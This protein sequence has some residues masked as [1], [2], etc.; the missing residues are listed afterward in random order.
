MAGASNSLKCFLCT[1]TGIVAEYCERFRCAKQIQ[2]PLLL[3]Y[4]SCV[5]LW[6]HFWSQLCVLRHRDGIHVHGLYD[7]FSNRAGMCSSMRCDIFQGVR[8]MERSPQEPSNWWITFDCFELY[9][10]SFSAI[11]SHLVVSG[12]KVNNTSTM[13]HNIRNSA[14]QQ[15]MIVARFGKI[16]HPIT[17]SQVISNEHI[18]TVRV[19][20][21]YIQSNMYSINKPNLISIWSLTSFSTLQARYN[22][23]MHR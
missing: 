14:T 20:I 5:I 3:N 8:P 17:P 16:N 10:L 11:I 15:L 23:S 7:L 19:C 1:T 2:S 9:S 18:E 21:S 13:L 4:G 6:M 22:I 12:D